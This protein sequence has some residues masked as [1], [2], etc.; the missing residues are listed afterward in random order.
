GLMNRSIDKWF[1]RPVEMLHEDTSQLATLLS[2]YAAANARAEADAISESPRV[3]HAF[4]TENFSDLQPELR[5]R[6]ATLQGGFVVLLKS[7]DEVASYRP[8]ADWKTMQSRLAPVADAA[9]A[10]KSNSASV[11]GESV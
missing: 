5:R 11:A 1:S 4:A 10:A 3:R 9:L 6:N 2:N 8:P 7:G